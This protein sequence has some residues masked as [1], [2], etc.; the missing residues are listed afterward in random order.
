M[1]SYRSLF[2][3]CDDGIMPCSAAGCQSFH[4]DSWNGEGG[5]KRR[6]AKAALLC[7]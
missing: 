7:E 6:A 4:H 5:Q 3:S 1:N 2:V